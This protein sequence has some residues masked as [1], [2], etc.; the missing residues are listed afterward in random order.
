[1][2]FLHCFG[3]K[4]VS[5]ESKAMTLY[6]LDDT[7][8]PEPGIFSTLKQGKPESPQIYEWNKLLILLFP[9][10]SRSL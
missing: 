5:L 1:M 7:C 2:G 9:H 3:N 8:I 10:V 4:T 6:I